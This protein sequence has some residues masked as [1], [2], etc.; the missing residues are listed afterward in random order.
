[1]RNDDAKQV[2]GWAVLYVTYPDGRRRTLAEAYDT[3]TWPSAK[4]TSTSAAPAPQ[5]ATHD[6]P[7]PTVPARRDDLERLGVFCLEGEWEARLDDR[8]SVEP[9]L[10]MLEQLAVIRFIRRDAATDVELEHY[11]SRWR[12]YGS[13]RLLY[14]GFHGERDWLKVQPE[15]VTL[16]WLEDRLNGAA[17]G[18]TIHFG[19]CSVLDLPPERL[20][21][22]CRQT[23][24]RGI[25]GYC[26]AIDWL[27]SVAFELALVQA[28]QQRPE[29]PSYAY[30]FM[31]DFYGDQARVLGFVHHPNP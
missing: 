14:L 23:G 28:L 18:R 12:R 11:L 4:G 25:S 2:N 27:D 1:M 26:R 13:Y 5:A 10:Q 8:L 3:R 29:R 6:R 31:H 17:D 16:D 20:A 7:Q 30:R 24:A 22:F 21:R 19:S 9:M 15:G